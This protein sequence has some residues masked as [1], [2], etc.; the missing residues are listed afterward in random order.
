[1]LYHLDSMNR[2]RT[3]PRRISTEH[4]RNDHNHRF[5]RGR[6]ALVLSTNTLDPDALHVST[7]MPSPHQSQ[8][9]HHPRKESAP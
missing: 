8:R 5:A 1:L 7:I 4:Q 3:A 9:V 6:C 2:T